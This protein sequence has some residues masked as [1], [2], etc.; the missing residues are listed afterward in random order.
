MSLQI[1][2]ISHKDCKSIPVRLSPTYATLLY[3]G[4]IT[5][6][7]V[8]LSLF[9][10]MPPI[11]PLPILQIFVHGIADTPRVIPISIDSNRYW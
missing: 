11:V 10:A 7:L 5:D 2:S 1:S 3:I 9:F 8:V 6:N 4:I